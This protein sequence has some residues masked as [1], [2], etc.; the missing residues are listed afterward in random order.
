LIRN[1]VEAHVLRAFRTDHGVPV[2]EVRKAIRFAEERFG[3]DRRLLSEQ[4]WTDAGELFLDRYGESIDLS[5]SGQLAMRQVLQAHLKRVTWSQ[6][7]P[8]RLYPFVGESAGTEM[9]IAIDPEISFGRPV[10]AN[11]GIS[12]KAITD[13][14][15]AGESVEDVA[16]DYE[17]RRE[18]IEQAVLYERAA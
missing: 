1:L 5:A 11:D 8:V 15:D 7:L 2:K 16:A 18:D 14:L 12:T 6:R 17:L 13:R 4:I 9:P 10:L 3:I